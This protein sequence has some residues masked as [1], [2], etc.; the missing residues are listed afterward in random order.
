[1]LY[2]RCTIY[3]VP[4]HLRAELLLGQRC[5]TQVDLYSLGA[6]LRKRLAA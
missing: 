3:P 5:D 1:M 2:P 4:W 6:S